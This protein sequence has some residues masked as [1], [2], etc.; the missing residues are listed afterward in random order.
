MIKPEVL[1]ELASKGIELHLL[2]A[3]GSPDNYQVVVRRPNRGEYKR[4]R[5]MQSDE[6][7]K[8]AAVEALLFDV[9]VYPERPELNRML[10]ERPALADVFGAKVLELAGLTGEAEGKKL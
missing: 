5:A 1:S 2:S 9:L 6:K 10:D 7:Q 8:P 4:F 3:P